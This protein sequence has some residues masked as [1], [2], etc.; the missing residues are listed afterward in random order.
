MKITNRVTD[1]LFIAGIAIAHDVK[2]APS[3][4]AL[5]SAL[6]KLITERAKQEFPPNNIKEAIRAMLRAGGFKP[7]GR[8]K[9]ASEYLAQAARD[10]RFPLINNLVDINN[11]LS[12]ETGFPISLLDL[13]VVSESAELRLGNDGEK[14]VFN[15]GGQEI[16]LKGLV[17]VCRNEPESMPLG[18]PVKDSMAGKLK[19]N[20]NSVI[21][22]IYGT[23]TL[24]DPSE[25]ERITAR[26]AALLHEYG[27]ASRV[28]S[29]VL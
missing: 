20:T 2:V 15:Q 18:N 9:P 10:G 21:G 6:Q 3:P 14:Y 29:F 5:V 8:N 11:L 25:M 28:E 17:C 24:T 23:K 22:V 16:E 26:F 12:L 1:P 7:A 19:E 27:S 4:A 13:A